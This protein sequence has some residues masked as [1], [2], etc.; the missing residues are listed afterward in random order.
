MPNFCK[1]SHHNANSAPATKNAKARSIFT[2]Y[3]HAARR[4]AIYRNVSLRISK[5]RCAYLSLMLSYYKLTVTPIDGQNA[6]TE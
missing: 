6:C 1:I 4:R 5:A 2:L 3:T